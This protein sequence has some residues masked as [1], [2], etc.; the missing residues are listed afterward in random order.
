MSHYRNLKVFKNDL[1]LAKLTN[2][3][4]GFKWKIIW[5]GRKELNKDENENKY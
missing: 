5:A 3:L 1:R 2:C 4:T